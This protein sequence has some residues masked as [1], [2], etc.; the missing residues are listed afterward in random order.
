MRYCRFI[1][2]FKYICT[3]L[4]LLLFFFSYSPPLS[5]E[6]LFLSL[7]PSLPLFFPSLPPSLSLFS[8]SLFLSLPPSPPLLPIQC[9]LTLRDCDVQTVDAISHMI[10]YCCWC[11]Q[12]FSAC[13]IEELQVCSLQP[14]PL[15]LLCT[16]CHPLHKHSH[17]HTL[18]LSLSL[19]HT[20]IRCH[21]MSSSLT[22]KL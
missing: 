14:L 7:L 4:C 17:T 3:S 12:S 9:I 16:L 10:C 19:R 6:P 8:P 13:I 22:L 1:G 18:S 2:L 15:S 11:N 20:F 5:L 21:L